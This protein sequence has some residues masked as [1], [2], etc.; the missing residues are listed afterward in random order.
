[1]IEK[2]LHYEIRCV[3]KKQDRILKKYIKDIISYY[4]LKSCISIYLCNRGI[5]LKIID[6]N[7]NRID[8]RLNVLIA[9]YNKMDDDN[10]IRINHKKKINNNN[11]NNNNKKKNNVKKNNVKTKKNEMI[12]DIFYIEILDVC[13]FCSE[14][15]ENLVTINNRKICKQCIDS[16]VEYHRHK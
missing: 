10:K 13:V 8:E 1:M 15:T 14:N 5:S 9:L 2:L 12:D 16:I 6:S 3:S 7:F 4:T 11:N